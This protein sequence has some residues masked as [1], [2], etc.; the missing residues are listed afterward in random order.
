MHEDSPAPLLP[1]E[2]S[3]EAEN[4]LST[5]LKPTSDLVPRP[6]EG[7]ASFV[8]DCEEEARSACENEPL[9]EE[10]QGKH[11]CVL[12]Y[13]G[14]EKKAVF[15]QAIQRKLDNQNFNFCGVWFPDQP[16]FRGFHFNSTADFS[17][18]TFAGHAA[19]NQAT[20]DAEVS[21][22]SA[23]FNSASTFIGANFNKGV[24][25]YSARF[26]HHA[27]FSSTNISG[28]ADFRTATFGGTTIEFSDANFN[29]EVWFGE[30]T[31]SGHATFK[32]A[33][34]KDEASFRSANFVGSEFSSSVFNSHADFSY[35]LF[36]G[37]AYFD[38]VTFS[39][40]VFF[41]CATFKAAGS[42]ASVTFNAEAVFS[43][44]AFSGNIQFTNS[45]FAGWADFTSAHFTY[46][47]FS[48]VEFQKQAR[49]DHARFTAKTN[50]KGSNFGKLG[51]FGS[52]ELSSDV[53]FSYSRITEGIDFASATIGGQLDFSYAKFAGNLRFSSED[54][55]PGFG[56]QSSLDLQ[57]ASIDKSDRI[58]FHTVRLRPHWFI[59][60]DPR[61]FDFSNV[62]WRGLFE[63]GYV[64]D[65]EITFAKRKCAQSLPDGQA[66]PAN[67]LL[68]IACW[69][70]AVNAEENHRYDEA[71]KL[72]FWA[73]DARRKER[74]RGYAVWTLD[75]WYGF[76]SG[77][78]ELT[79]RAFFWLIVIWLLF[80]P[81]YWRA[82][83][84]RNETRI[85]SKDSV[86]KVEQLDTI[87]RL[88]L[89]R[90][91]TYSLEVMTIQKPE[92]RPAT[93]RVRLAVLIETFLG[94][95][96]AALL[97][98]AIRRK[99]MR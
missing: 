54:G 3:A 70:L 4:E 42:F 21:F 86:F 95:L 69:R 49:F 65:D 22:H 72:R 50:F 5:G 13:P 18:A 60:V 84:L 9:Y 19:F 23:N 12:H 10:Y 79:F 71:S 68:A 99:F 91:L 83:F 58:S 98:L 30:S 51:V 62:T 66:S 81:I 55:K 89:Q 37:D 45:A 6:L 36:G 38:S 82:D 14:K 7:E 64:I 73:M 52:C 34:F 39:A 33:T 77:Y 35:A 76:A 32:S 24:S 53:D 20:F 93:S 48:D 16:P 26:N 57:Y 46:T 28:R 87:Q 29:G 90:A 41:K 74:A 1:S 27:Y 43:S 94:P 8:C 17:N 2:D 78:G 92:P 61:K 75:W 44:A 59:N 80:V 97:A 40:N 67:R 11:Y 15:R 85:T 63:K 31:F 88:P 96:Q 25:F 56:D 47:D